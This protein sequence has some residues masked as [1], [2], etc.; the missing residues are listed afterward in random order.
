[1]PRVNRKWVASCMV[2]RWISHVV[3]REKA[4]TPF[5]QVHS[6]RFLFHI[7]KAGKAAIEL[8]FRGGDR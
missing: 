7:D 2:D 3:L 5:N 1:M 6:E 4:V 8:V